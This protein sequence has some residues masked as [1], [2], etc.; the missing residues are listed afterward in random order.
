MYTS[1]I[2]P[3]IDVSL[4]QF[5]PPRSGSAAGDLIGRISFLVNGFIR[6]RNLPVRCS[7]D[8]G[9]RI[10]FP[11]PVDCPCSDLPLNLIRD[12]IRAEIEARVLSALDFEEA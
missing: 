2:S 10:D 6:F 7:S 8:N 4:V 3:K 9:V 12:D 5:T 1:K 11:G